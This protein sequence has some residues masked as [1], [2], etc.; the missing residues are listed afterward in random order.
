M[1]LLLS[2]LQRHNRMWMQKT[3]NGKKYYLNVTHMEVFL[4][5]TVPCYNY[6]C[7]CYLLYYATI[8]RWNALQV[9]WPILFTRTKKSIRKSAS[10]A[11]AV[12]V[13]EEETEYAQTWKRWWIKRNGKCAKPANHSEKIKIKK[14]EKAAPTPPPPTIKSKIRRKAQERGKTNTTPILH[15]HSGG[16]KLHLNSG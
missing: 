6:W 3:S 1:H 16:K 2:I 5:S 4:I 14:W 11:A 12:I 7:C 9:C 13:M 10:V 15:S 8:M